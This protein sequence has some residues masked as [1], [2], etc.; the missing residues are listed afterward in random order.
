MSWHL[1]GYDGLTVKGMSGKLMLVVIRWSKVKEEGPCPCSSYSIVAFAT[2][3]TTIAGWNKRRGLHSKYECQPRILPTLYL[4]ATIMFPALISPYFWS[5]HCTNSYMVFIFKVF[6][7]LL[8][9]SNLHNFYMLSDWDRFTFSITWSLSLILIC[10][11]FS[12]LKSS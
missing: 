2:S 5:F 6:L 4:F 3:S 7:F 9:L 12:V 10:F 8:W 1:K 11:C